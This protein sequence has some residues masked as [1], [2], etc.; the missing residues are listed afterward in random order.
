MIN[1][2]FALD[3]LLMM[4]KFFENYYYYIVVNIFYAIDLV[5]INDCYIIFKR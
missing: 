4:K 3:Y 1:C 2:Y 5:I